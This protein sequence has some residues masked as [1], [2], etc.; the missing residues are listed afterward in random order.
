M[1]KEKLAQLLTHMKRYG[2]INN[3]DIPSLIEE[4]EELQAS[5]KLAWVQLEQF[6]ENEIA[7]KL[8]NEEE[9]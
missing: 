3:E 6:D 7:W 4:I 8:I 9:L 2:T 1:N 5:E